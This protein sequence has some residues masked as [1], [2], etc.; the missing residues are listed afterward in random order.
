MGCSN[1]ALGIETPGCDLGTDVKPM[2]GNNMI[3]IT[4][5]YVDTSVILIYMAL[6]DICLNMENTIHDIIF[7]SHAELLLLL[8]M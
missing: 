1:G 4:T 7:H 2:G 6:F 3:T 8:I 5:T